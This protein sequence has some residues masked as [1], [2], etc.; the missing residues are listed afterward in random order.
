[1][2]NHLVIGLGGTGGKKSRTQATTSN[3]STMKMT[4]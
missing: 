4:T 3:I 1:M 2:A